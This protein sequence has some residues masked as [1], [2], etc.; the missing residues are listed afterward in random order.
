M[1]AA[2]PS[3]PPAFAWDEWYAAAGGRS[4]RIEEAAEYLRRIREEHEP[5]F[6]GPVAPRRHDF[7]SANEA[8]RH[9]KENAAEFGAYTASISELEARDISSRRTVS[10]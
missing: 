2:A 7:P 8:A 10:A 3:S 1:L 4:I 6:T 5:R 9:L